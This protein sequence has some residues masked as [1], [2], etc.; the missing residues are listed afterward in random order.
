M[1]RQHIILEKKEYLWILRLIQNL[2]FNNPTEQ[3]CIDNL[4]RELKYAIVKDESDMPDHIV[5]LNS[6][7]SVDTP[8]GPKT[9]LQ[10]V[11]PSERNVSQDK[12]SVLS[13]MGSALIGYGKGDEVNWIFPKGK[14]KIRIMNVRNDRSPVLN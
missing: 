14:G 13:P 9:G 4:H 2:K 3:K 1:K 12:I 10:L 6:I 7:V 11:A 8:Y 5:R